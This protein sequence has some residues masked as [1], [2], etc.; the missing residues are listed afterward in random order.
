MIT[1]FPTDYV[2]NLQQQIQP[3]YCPRY[4][5]DQLSRDG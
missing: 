1:H 5:A 2:P 4:T 3:I